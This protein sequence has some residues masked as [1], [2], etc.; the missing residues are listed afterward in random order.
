MTRHTR[1]EPGNGV[2]TSTTWKTDHLA[3]SLGLVVGI[4]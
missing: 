3:A 2:T 1:R 4:F